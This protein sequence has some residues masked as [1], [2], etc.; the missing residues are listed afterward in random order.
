M[1]KYRNVIT[2]IGDIRFDSRKEAQHWRDL[3]LLE[4]ARKITDLK[5]QPR[6]DFYVNDKKLCTYRA[7]FSYR[8]NGELIIV[9]VKSKPTRTPVYMLKRKLMAAA[10][11]ITIREV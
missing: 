10:L 3:C 1:R 7:D 9:D 6:F 2:Y 5:R 4:R 11:G 8:E